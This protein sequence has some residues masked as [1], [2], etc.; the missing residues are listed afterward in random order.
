MRH[1][2]LNPESV[3]GSTAWLHPLLEPFEGW[4]AVLHHWLLCCIVFRMIALERW[5]LIN[6]TQIPPLELTLPLTSLM[7]LLNHPMVIAMPLA[8]MEMPL[9]RILGGGPSSRS[10]S[11]VIGIVREFPLIQLP[12]SSG[13]AIYNPVSF[14]LI[15]VSS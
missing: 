9:E 8:M 7:R 1:P 11:D 3:K 15:Q 10:A 13:H 5:R 12:L 4:A 6:E 2:L 14:I